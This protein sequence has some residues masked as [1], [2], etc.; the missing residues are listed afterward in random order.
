L[1]QTKT[2]WLVEPDGK[3]FTEPIS[4]DDITAKGAADKDKVVVEMITRPIDK[5][6][7]RG[8]ILEVLGRAGAFEAE[9][10]SIICQYK[11]PRQFS[12]DC[13]EQARQAADSFEN[14]GVEEREDITGKT[15]I[16]IDP[17]DAKDFD[18][19]ISLEKDKDG[20]SVLGVHIADVS[21]FI[22]ARTPLDDEARERG[23][24]AYLPVYARFSPARNVS[25]KALISLTAKMAR[26]CKGGSQIPLCP[27]RKGSLTCRRIKP[28]KA[29]K[30][31]SNRR[32]SNS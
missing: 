7:A 15:I 25:S 22:P 18:D 4:I 20:N 11:L 28:S 21:S 10:N 31:K 3:N 8:V 24:S 2:G 1:R 30:R 12:E 9:I 27:R 32:S 5:H 26:F 23:N 17:P 29:T 16:T 19:A 13:I 14:A 6:L